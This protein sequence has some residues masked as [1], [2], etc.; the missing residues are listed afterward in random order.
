MFKFDNVF[1]DERSFHLAPSAQDSL[2]E[3]EELSSKMTEG[4]CAN[5]K[6][7][8]IIRLRRLLPSLLRNATSLSEGGFSETERQ[9]EHIR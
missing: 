7:D 9:R 3:L 5:D 1:P 6:F 2:C 8:Q 4:E